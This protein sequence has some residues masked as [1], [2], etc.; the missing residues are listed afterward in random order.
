MHEEENVC[1]P[2][3]NKRGSTQT[4]PNKEKSF[5]QKTKEEIMIQKESR[6]VV[7]DNSGAKEVLCIN[8]LGSKRMSARAGDVIVVAI[9][10]AIP[11]GAL[12][13]GQMAKAVI[14]RTKYDELRGRA[15]DRIRF[16]D[17]ACV[18]INDD[19]GPKGT[20]VFGPVSRVLRDKK[21][22]RI[23]SLAPEVL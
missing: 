22:T 14:V 23:V 3:R 1:F 17:N 19:K 5:S 12:K 20:R 13:K 6:L 15:D 11:N 18:I 2:L 10:K 4:A 8:I 16:D 21:F 9:K 7:A